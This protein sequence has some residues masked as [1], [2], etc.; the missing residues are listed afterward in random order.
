MPIK[1]LRRQVKRR[2]GRGEYISFDDVL[3]IADYFGVS[4][5]A[6]LFRIAYR[7][8]AISGNLEGSELK[9]RARAYGPDKVRKAKHMTHAKLYAGLID[10]YKEQL[11]LKQS[12][13]ARFLF[14]NQYIYNDSRMEG[15]NVEREQAAEIV[16]D[17]RLNMQK[18]EFCN[19]ENEAYLSVAGHYDM[20][21]TK[22]DIL[23]LLQGLM[24]MVITVGC[25]KQYLS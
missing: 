18:S 24:N 13:H 6:C 5:E 2:Q 19:E 12:D 4:F 11:S 17:L 20:L 22:K 3:E 16:T 9:D 23:K 25:M 7:I 14:Q 15:L 10:C 1:E 8:G 21:K